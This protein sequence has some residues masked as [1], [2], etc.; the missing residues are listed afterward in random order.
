MCAILHDGT[1]ARATKG[2]D[3]LSSFC[4]PHCDFF[5]HPE[6][7]WRTAQKHRIPAIGYVNKLDRDGA[8]FKHVLKTLE[9]RLGVTPLALQVRRSLSLTQRMKLAL[10]YKAIGTR[11]LESLRVSRWC[12]RGEVFGH[13]IFYFLLENDFVM[14][15]T[16]GCKNGTWKHFSSR[17]PF[18]IRP[19][20]NHQAS[21]AVVT[22]NFLVICIFILP[23][24]GRRYLRTH[25]HSAIQKYTCNRFIL[26]CFSWRLAQH[27]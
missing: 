17:G 4:R 8:D 9:R 24:V 20:L 6:T 15:G 13:D 1:T 21:L 3:F 19:L 25:G 12:I 27:T 10:Q 5:Q 26:L 11:V 2:P 16:I 22:L 23:R 14:Q 7:V 18:L